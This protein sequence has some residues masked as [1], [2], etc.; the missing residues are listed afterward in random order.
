VA[1]SVAPFTISAE[2]FT[3]AFGQERWRFV[4]HGSNGKSTRSL[5]VWK[6]K[7]SALRAA[8]RSW[9]DHV[10]YADIIANAR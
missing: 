3:N 1:Y 10:H 8:H 2:K 4:M 7:S 6:H 9:S 5:N